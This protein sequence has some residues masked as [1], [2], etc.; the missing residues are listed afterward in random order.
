MGEREAAVTGFIDAIAPGIEALAAEIGEHPEIGYQEERAVAAISRMLAD[1]GHEAVVGVAGMPTGLRAESGTS[2]P[3][4]AILAE[5]DALPEIGHACGHN[6][7]G[8]AAVGAYLAVA[9]ADPD[10]RYLLLGC[11]AE[12]SSVNGAGGKIRLIEAAVFDDVAAALM[13][14]PYDASTIVT[15][16]A[17]AARGVEF[18]FRGRGAHAAMSPHLGVNALDAVV[19]CYTAI[20]QLRQQLRPETR[21]H[22]II[23]DGG[24]SPN[25]IP[26]RAALRMRLRAPTLAELEDTFERVRG[27]AEGAALATG[28]SLEADEFM[29]P[30]AEMR[31][32]PALSEIGRGVLADLGVTP[33]TDPRSAVFGSSD[34][35]NVSHR[36]PA[37]EIG[38]QV[39][40][41]GT[42][43]HTV[44]F[45]RAACSPR[46]ARAAVTGA[47]AIALS[48]LRYRSQGV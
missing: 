23:S 11:P 5:Y 3:R 24:A 45:A 21:V 35:G 8:A 15:E 18:V 40:D 36:V 10:G 25:V 28:C 1:A 6:V 48:A 26:D 16:G 2:G 33:P 4:I 43:P 39:A 14:H 41:E 19:Q 13:I 34:F 9:H 47:R 29:P 38:I 12:E 44:E 22:G 31:Q 37:L 27:C 20:A 46:G 32:D 7:I 17:L 30:Y 42:K